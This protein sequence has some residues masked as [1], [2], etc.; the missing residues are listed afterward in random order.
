[1]AV[2]TAVTLGPDRAPPAV[3]PESRL[4]PDVECGEMPQMEEQQPAPRFRHLARFGMYASAFG[5]FACGW[6]AMR[7][8]DWRQIVGLTALAGVA[9][10]AASAFGKRAG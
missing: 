1:M 4:Y 10:I 5:V 3:S 8:D 9:G 7:T 2:I 6:L